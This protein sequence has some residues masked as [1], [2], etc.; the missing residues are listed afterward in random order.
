MDNLD[1]KYIA[2][3]ELPVRNIKRYRKEIQNNWDKLSD[4]QKKSL[5]TTM[6]HFTPS[7]DSCIMNMA[8]SSK[9]QLHGL[10]DALIK[11]TPD[12]RVKY[13]IT[14]EDSKRVKEAMYDWNVKNCR[15]MLANWKTGLLLFLL[16]IL[17]VG[18]IIGCAVNGDKLPL[19]TPA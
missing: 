9:H 12:Q 17:V 5:G 3:F 2:E 13:G 11:P 18:L 10:F 4:A 8:K 7:D 1:D 15:V 6:E 16:L 19:A 14:V